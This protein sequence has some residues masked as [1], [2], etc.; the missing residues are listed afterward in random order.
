MTNV[1]G[2]LNLYSACLNLKNLKGIVSITSDKVYE[3]KEQYQSY[4]E[5]D[6]LGGLDMYSS[7]KACMELMTA[8]FIRAFKD[9]LS[10]QIVTARS[11]NVIGGGDWAD[12]RLI[13]DLMKASEK[14]QTVNVI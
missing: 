14:N 12:D 7:S 8:S 2:S 11:G 9:K 13:P 3:N 5:E 4:T 1:M 10:F 6:E